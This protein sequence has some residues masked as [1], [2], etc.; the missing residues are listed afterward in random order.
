VVEAHREGIDNDPEFLGRLQLFKE[1]AMA[2]IMRDDSIPLPPPPEEAAVQLYYDKHLEEFTVPAKIHIHEVLLSDEL[3]AQKLRKEL[4]LFEEFK[5]AAEKYTERLGKRIGGG[6]IGYIEKRWYPE[7]FEEAWKTP[8]GGIG[9]PVLTDKG[10]YALFYVVD[11]VD[12]ELK[13][14]LGLKR[15]IIQKLINKQKKDAFEKWVEERQQS[16]RIIV[17]EDVLWSTIDKNKF[18]L[19]DTTG[20][21]D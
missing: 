19:V 8:V 7:V 10:K 12:K 15:E 6:D 20:S 4:N 18:A 2:E 1:L 5:K 16:T 13:D 9:G 3:K 11:K 17:N 21:S 14:Y